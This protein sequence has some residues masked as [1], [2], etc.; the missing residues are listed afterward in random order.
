MRVLRCLRR[1]LAA[2][3]GVLSTGKAVFP[4]KYWVLCLVCK[5]KRARGGALW[6]EKRWTRS[7]KWCGLGW[8]L[9]GVGCGQGGVEEVDQ[10]AGGAVSAEDLA[11]EL[12]V[13]D[14]RGGEGGGES[15]AGG[16]EEV[17]GGMAGGEAFGGAGEGVAGVGGEEA[18]ESWGAEEAAEG[19]VTF[20]QAGAEG[21]QLGGGGH[22]EAGGDVDLGGGE[23]EVV[24]GTG[25]PGHAGA[26]PP[27]GEVGF[28]G[29]LVRGEAGI[30]V[31]AEQGLLGRADVGGGE[32]GHGEG[33][34]ADE[35]EHGGFQLLLEEFA[36]GFEPLA[37]VVAGE[38]AEEAQGVF[39]EAGQAGAGRERRRKAFGWRGGHGGERS[40]GRFL[41][42]DLIRRFQGPVEIYSSVPEMSCCFP[43]GV[44][45]SLPWV[46]QR[47]AADVMEAK[48][49]VQQGTLALMVLKTLDVMGA[50]HGYGL[51]RRIEQISGDLLS[52][53][54]GTLYP[55]LL[56]LEQEGA[57]TSEWGPSENNRRARFYRLT[58]AG[59]NLL[60]A[61]KRDW[62]QSAAIIARF[63]EVKAEELG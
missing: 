17:E 46:S 51:A 31:D 62:D 20:K 59:H 27:G 11:G 10:G 47:R 5:Q 12:L 35:G 19:G 25:G 18:I 53:N 52:V 29:A 43:R 30:A 61:E 4:Q 21:A 58:G 16:Q 56:R 22:V 40:P 45:R 34:L 3:T 8:I 32:A 9:R 49:E 60:E 55:V 50:L 48:R 41:P 7:G 38:A 1:Y 33:D 36:A 26:G 57:I 42:A 37:A 63:F 28:V 15:P 39:G 13:E 24:A 2:F 14:G 23:V 44:R 6:R 54:Q